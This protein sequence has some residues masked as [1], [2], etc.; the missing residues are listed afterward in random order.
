MIGNRD[1]IHMKSLCIRFGN[2]INLSTKTERQH[3]QIIKL[4]SILIFL[5][6]WY[7]LHNVQRQYAVIWQNI[8][9]ILKTYNIQPKY[10]SKYVALSE[11]VLSQTKEYKSFDYKPSTH[12][13]IG[14][15]KHDYTKSFTPDECSESCPA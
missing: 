4:G 10:L 2:V 11:D 6:E 3:K 7:D 9:E 5:R 8:E 15:Q 14:Y 13:A 12:Y 1:Y